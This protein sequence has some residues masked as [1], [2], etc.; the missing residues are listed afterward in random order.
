M[1]WPAVRLLT[2]CG[3]ALSSEFSKAE[4]DAAAEYER[5]QMWLELLS[6]EDLDFINSQLDFSLLEHFGL[7]VVRSEEYLEGVARAGQGGG[8]SKEEHM[9]ML[10]LLD[11]LTGTSL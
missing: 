4:F 11:S 6:E 1:G 3:R 10:G 2:R 5:Q 7:A 8:M 9:R